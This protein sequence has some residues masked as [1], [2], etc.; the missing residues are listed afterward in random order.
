[1]Q[2]EVST[3]SRERRGRRKWS[4]QESTVLVA[5]YEEARDGGMGLREFAERHDVAPSTLQHW[6]ARKAGL[7]ADPAL[8]A[9]FE[10]PAGLAFL[11]RLVLAAVFQ[12]CQ[13]G[14]CGVDHVGA[15]LKLTGLNAF[16]AASHAVLRAV[17]DAMEG[18]IVDFG[19]AQR[20]ALAAKMPWRQIALC[21]DETFHP[22]VCLVAIEPA[23]NFILLERYAEN[24]EARTWTGAM[25]EALADLA[26]DVTMVATDEGR[27]L[28]AHVKRGLGVLSAPDLFHAMRDVWKALARP[29]RQS[30]KATLE[31]LEQ[32]EAATTAW[33][34]HRDDYASKARGPGRP[35]QFDKHIAQAQAVQDEARAAYRQAVDRCDAAEAAIRNLSRAYHPVDLTTAALRDADVVGHDI[36][37]AFETIDATATAIGLSPDGRGLIDKAR[38]V[39]PKLVAAIAFFHANVARRLAALPVDDAIREHIRTQL[40]PALYLLRVAGQAATAAER[41]NLRATGNRLLIGARAGLDGVLDPLR[42][43]IEQIARECVNAFVRATSC[44]EGRNGQLALRHHSL[45][46]LS[47]RRLATLTVIHNFHIRRPDNTTAARRFFGAAHDDLFEWLL[48]HIEVPARPRSRLALKAA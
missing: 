23:S 18:E 37:T 3:E 26:V 17:A 7:D 25:N 38:R 10:S 4:R 6:L 36:A 22:A 45:H 41:E 16:V 19:A 21:Q 33:R 39:M 48:D 24:R 40:I 47:D 1:M 35:P 9:F 44:V 12:F 5:A 27:G 14:P 8:V 43:D 42:S 13:V 46:R 28:V 20:Q 34:E 32:A 30:L 11:H 29:L 15:F 2:E 31:A